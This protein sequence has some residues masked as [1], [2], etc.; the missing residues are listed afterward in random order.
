MATGD[1]LNKRFLIKQ[2]LGSGAEGIVY[3]V[4]DVENKHKL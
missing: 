2:K 1:I 4:E 3:L